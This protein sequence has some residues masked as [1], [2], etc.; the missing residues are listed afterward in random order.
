MSGSGGGFM[1]GMQGGMQGGMS[2]S[3]RRQGGMRFG[4]GSAPYPMAGWLEDL[5][6]KSVPGEDPE[7]INDLTLVE[8]ALFPANSWNPELKAL[9]VV[10]GFAALEWQAH[11]PANP[12]SFAASIPGEIRTLV[13]YIPY[14]STFL[15]EIVAQADDFTGYWAQALMI[16]PWSHPRSWTLL[17]AAT[18]IGA[19]VATHWKATFGHPRP[20]Q[21]FPGLMPP[22][23]VPGHPSYPS[24]HALQSFLIAECFA[25]VTAP[26][27]SML[28]QL[29]VR[30]AMLREIAGV[31]FAF[32]A[33]GSDAIVGRRSATDAEQPPGIAK[34]LI[35]GP[36]AE[37]IAAAR[38]EFPGEK[39]GKK[40]VAA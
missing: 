11:A 20:S 14:R 22:I 39:A 25:A 38:H 36:A 37:L 7:I 3:A 15:P 5:P 40:P 26:R 30:I 32:D 23:P 35:D 24:G 13:N 2:L 8:G 1:G 28:R 9:A 19:M 18:A 4:A 29:A 33:A 10:G 21:V 12:V 16:T 27:A 17:A 6:Y 34:L 31:H